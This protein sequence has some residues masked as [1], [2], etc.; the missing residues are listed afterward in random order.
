MS[1]DA[2]NVKLP[3]ALD[4]QNRS[5]VSSSGRRWWKPWSFFKGNNLA[6][7]GMVISGLFL[8]MAAV[9]PAL[10][11]YDPIETNLRDRLEGPSL[12]HLMGTDELG[13]DI[14]SRIL[15]GARV[16]ISIALMSMGLAILFG[17]ALGMTGGYFGGRWDMISMRALDV[18]LAIP[19]LVLAIA[20]VSLLGFG[21]TNL[22]IAVSVTRIPSLARLARASV[23]TK[24]C[25]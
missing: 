20:I 21:T 4:V 1:S 10:A 11:P 14:W 15:A 23:L 9:G 12:D 8:L 22:I 19:D 3:H 18:L 24:L 7:V 13:R 17:V 2:N 16:S 25:F 6:V 5:L